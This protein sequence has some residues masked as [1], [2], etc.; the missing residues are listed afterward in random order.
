MV[1]IPFMD[2]KKHHKE[3]D[4]E[5]LEIFRN[6]L[7]SA[8]FIN[9]QAVTDFESKFAQY[10][11]TKFAIGVG[12]GTD[13]LRFSLMSIGVQTGDI[14]ITVPNTFIATTEAI[15][16]A[17]AQPDFVDIDADTMCMS[18][19][20]LNEYLEDRCFVD[21]LTGETIN[22]SFGK[23]VRAV[24]PVHLFG[25][26][27]NMDCI[28][29]IAE[30]YNISIIEDACQAHGAQYYSKLSNKIIRA[31]GY[32]SSGSFS[33]YPGKNLGACGEAGAITT[34]DEN[35][36][37]TVRMLR[38]H[39]QVEKYNHEIEGYNGRLD[40][41]QAAILITKLKYLDGW[42][43]ERKRLA[44]VYNDE[45]SGIDEITLPFVPEWSNPVYHLY[46]IRVKK[47]DNLKTFLFENGI[48]TALHYP[49]PLHLQKAYQYLGY[50]RGIFPISEQ[51]ADTLLSIP[52]HPWLTESEQLSVV[53]EIKRYFKKM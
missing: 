13:A 9:G 30:K 41:I 37:N 20:K 27:V 39:G 52:L 8:H 19:E 49:I 32:S 24:I 26:M 25:Q 50:S 35:I 38:D 16:Q 10:C 17:G 6:V 1:K 3:R 23:T 48:E 47:R 14:V 29:K 7:H 36:M 5:Y 34:D 45:L 51:C 46:V 12:S 53:E 28:N 15:T 43:N 11:G 33:F 42:N 21:D 31:G 18:C 40:T 22:K 2:L 4:F 44:K